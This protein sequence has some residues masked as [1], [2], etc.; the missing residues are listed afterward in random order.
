MAALETTT[1][2][3][4]IADFADDAARDAK[5]ADRD[6]LLAVAA[7]R[8]NLDQ[9]EAAIEQNLNVMGSVSGKSF[10]EEDAEDLVAALRKRGAAYEQ[11]VLFQHLSK[12]VA[13]KTGEE[14]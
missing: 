8:R 9:I 4:D 2:A 5:N 3:L 12:R 1:I 13:A 7:L 10:A 14:A 6:V 11:V